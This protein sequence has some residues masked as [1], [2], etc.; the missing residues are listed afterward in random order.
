MMIE[1]GDVILFQGDSITDTGR[2][3]PGDVPNAPGALGWGY[4]GRV[5]GRVL[6][7]R[8]ADDLKFYNRG[9]SGNRISDLYARWKVDALN[10][11]PTLISILIG[12]NDTWHDKKHDNGVEVPRYEMMY[13]E[14]LKWTRDVLPE[15]KLVLCEP[16]YTPCGNVTD[17]WIPEIKERQAIV[18]QLADEF[19]GTL[20]KFQTMFDA[21]CA[22]APP[23]DWAGDGVHPSTGGHQRMADFWCKT[24]L[25]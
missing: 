7:D 21:A 1:A 17:D 20:V 4:A 15:V 6:A 18:A 8:P 19:G 2:N 14:L 12:I 24:V 16:F 11:K 5:A 23:E 10:L 9:I 25:G 3:R 13:R 22:E